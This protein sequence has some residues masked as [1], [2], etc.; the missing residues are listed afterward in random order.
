MRL[1]SIALT[2]IVIIALQGCASLSSLTQ[3]AKPKIALPSETGQDVVLKS[4]GEV[5]GLGLPEPGSV[6]AANTKRGDRFIVIRQYWTEDLEGYHKVPSDHVVG[7]VVRHGDSDNLV[8]VPIQ[9]IT[10]SYLD[11]GGNWKIKHS[12]E[13]LKSPA[14]VVFE[15]RKR[16]DREHNNWQ[17]FL[18]SAF[19]SK[20]EFAGL[21]HHTTGTLYLIGDDGWHKNGTAR[22]D[23]RQV[24]DGLDYHF[25]RGKVLDEAIGKADGLAKMHND[26]RELLDTLAATIAK[27][28]KEKK[29]EV[30]QVVCDGNTHVAGVLEVSDDR[31]RIQ[32]LGYAMGDGDQIFMKAQNLD[33]PYDG[34]E[35]SRKWVDAD[36]WGACPVQLPK[37]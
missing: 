6:S 20:G 23:F 30:G 37:Q 17:K 13:G 8:T 28:A 19:D 11:L 16:V 32:M 29:K 26:R 7:A 2:L 15:H 31:I 3:S 10:D 5:V 1:L 25:E 35:P 4:P 36:Q 12:I 18:F 24:P 14:T 21:V 34:S 33:L 27:A 9:F 22:V